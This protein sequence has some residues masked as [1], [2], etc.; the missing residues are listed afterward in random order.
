MAIYV[1]H[2]T[3]FI[4]SLRI[5]LFREKFI[6]AHVATDDRANVDMLLGSC[7]LDDR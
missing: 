2:W 3:N 5:N 6:N 1:Q 4:I 7:S